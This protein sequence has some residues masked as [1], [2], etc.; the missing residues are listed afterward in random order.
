MGAP[1]LLATVRPATSRIPPADEVATARGVLNLV[2]SKL[3]LTS[4]KRIVFGDPAERLIAL[5]QRETASLIITSGPDPS[6]PSPGLF[7]NLFL[8]F[9]RGGPCPVVIVP[10]Q[11]E[12][13]R[14]AIGP[15]VCEIDGSAGSARAAGVATK[16]GYAL[17]TGVALLDVT[18]PVRG[19]DVAAVAARVGAQMVVT[20]ARVG[21]SEKALR[22][23]LSLS[24][25]ATSVS[26]PL[27]VVPARAGAHV[28]Y[29]ASRYTS[30]PGPPAARS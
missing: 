22:S 19:R 14:E 24:Q 15:V 25:L 17:G 3:A 4:D 5:A 13:Y 9:A 21:R 18:T 12:T 10:P 30:D 28:A 16:L 2:A 26:C 7:D 6:S 1:L 29:Q 11:V 8:A 23:T 27:V 20:A